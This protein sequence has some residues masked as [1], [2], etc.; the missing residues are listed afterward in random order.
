MLSSEKVK[1]LEDFVLG[2]TRTFKPV[3][4]QEVLLFARQR[5]IA[6]KDVHSFLKSF[7]PYLI[8]KAYKVKV[9]NY[10]TS[11]NNSLGHYH[12]GKY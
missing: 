6:K 5:G 3:R 2:L 4:K 11:L 1:L 8:N 10:P 12:V 9:R 7:F